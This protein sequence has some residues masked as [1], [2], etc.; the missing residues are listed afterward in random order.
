MAVCMYREHERQDREAASAAYV[1]APGFAALEVE[2]AA[3]GYRHATIAE[4]NAGA[5][6]APFAPDLYRW[7]GGLWVRTA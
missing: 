2:A 4:I 6:Q 1:L 7:K 5:Q 3:K